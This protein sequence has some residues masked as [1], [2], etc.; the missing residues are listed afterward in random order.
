MQLKESGVSIRD[1][2]SIGYILALFIR[3]IFRFISETFQGFLSS[4]NVTLSMFRWLLPLK[5]H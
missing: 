2:L 1:R 4:L 5:N 3:F